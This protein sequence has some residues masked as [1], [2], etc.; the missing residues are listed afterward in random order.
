MNSTARPEFITIKKNREI[1]ALLEGGKK[2]HT[3]YGIFFLSRETSL[4]AI[5]YAVLIKKSVGNAVWRNYCKRIVR[6]YI[7]NNVQK[8]SQFRKFIFLYN[9][10]GKI[11]YSDLIQEFNKRLETR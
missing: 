3:K 9:F 5:S 7:R 2:I 10:N 4:A 8:F 1:K 6:T 11:R